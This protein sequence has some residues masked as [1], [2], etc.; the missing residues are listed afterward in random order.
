MA[1]MRLKSDKALRKFLASPLDPGTFRVLHCLLCGA[2][3]HIRF[4]PADPGSGDPVAHN[5]Y[6]IERGEYLDD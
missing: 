3:T 5:R 4:G 6:H 1:N 2:L